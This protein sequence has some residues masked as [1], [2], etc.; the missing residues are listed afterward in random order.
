MT[1]LS[2]FSLQKPVRGNWLVGNNHDH[3]NL[4]LFKWSWSKLEKEILLYFMAYHFF[5]KNLDFGY[6]H[7]QNFDHLTSLK[8]DPETQT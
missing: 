1:I 5:M 4:E 7:G 6:G 3:D 2:F 8:F